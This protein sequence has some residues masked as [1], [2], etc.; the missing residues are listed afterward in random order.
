MANQLN[1]T[2]LVARAGAAAFHAKGNFYNSCDK[3][4]AKEYFDRG[5][6]PGMTINLPRP[7]RFDAKVGMIANPNNTVEDTVPLTV[8]PITASAVMT[9]AQKLL[10]MEDPDDFEKRIAKPL[11]LRWC[12]AAEIY[13]IQNSVRQMSMWMGSPGTS[14]GTYRNYSDAQA[15]LVDMLV[16]DPEGMMAALSPTTHS[17]LSDNLKALVNPPAT[18]ANQYLRGQVKDLAGFMAYRSQ[19]LSS[20]AGITNADIGTPLVMGANQTGST[21]TIDGFTANAIIPAGSKFTLQTP[22]A[23][24]PESKQILTWL[25]TFTVIGTQSTDAEGN[26]IWVDIVANGSGQA[27][28]PIYPPIIPLSQTNGNLQTVTVS[29]ADN[30]AVSFAGIGRTAISTNLCYAPEAIAV[31]SFAFSPLELKGASHVEKHEDFSIRVSILPDPK[32]RNELI[33]MDGLIGSCVLRPEWAMCLLG[34]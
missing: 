11:A 16:P 13:C 3:T 22:Y 12:R 29:P 26:P 7:A 15:R 2:Q 34:A 20:I 8:V 23:V 27:A 10:F 32:T 6:N 17:V 25:M 28:L 5:V 21:L 24:D 19:S 33:V 14:P 9:S 1:I 18:I 4:A 31:A 30:E